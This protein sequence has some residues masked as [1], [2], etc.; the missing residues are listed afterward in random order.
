[1]VNK[2]DKIIVVGSGINGMSTILSLLS[3]G[4]QHIEVFDKRNYDV[5]QWSY[6]NGCD[7]PSSDFNKFFRTA[8]GKETHYEKI[9]LASR[10]IVEHWNEMI[11][12]ENWE[13]GEPILLMTGN[14]HL[15]NMN[16]LDDFERDNIETIGPD[17]I[18]RFDDPMAKEKVVAAGLDPCAADPFECR[19]R[20]VHLQGII[21]TGSGLIQADKTC[22]WMLHLCKKMGGSRVNFHLGASNQVIQ[23]LEEYTNNSKK[24]IGVKTKDGKVHFS[25]LTIAACGPWLSEVVPESQERVEA[26]AGSVV[27]IKITDPKALAKYD[28]RK[29]PIWSWKLKDRG[30]GAVFG[31]PV[32]KDGWMK[33]GFRGL[34]WT[35]PQPGMN[36][37]IVTGWSESKQETNIPLYALKMMKMVIKMYIPEV[38]KIDLTRMCW[39]GDTEDNDYLIDFS[40]YHT[41]DSLFVIGGD[42]GHSFMMLGAMGDII[43]RIINKCEDKFLTNLFSWDRKREKKNVINR[44]LDD[45]RALQNQIMAS[46]KDWNI[47][48]DSKL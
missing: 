40:P 38:K 25:R 10:A 8:Y 28:E 17:R 46:P 45:P 16:D 9:A 44:G 6:F 42:S 3:H 23:L 22:R 30:I 39:Y 1:M 4:Y 21:D 34:K 47:Y 31:F 18:I 27:L 37:K 2:S 20:G 24:C 5:Q 41:D 26:T 13:G 35:N 48:G 33:I 32:T 36:S 14:V 29:F 11:K 19:K 15:T 7:S 43:L 12:K